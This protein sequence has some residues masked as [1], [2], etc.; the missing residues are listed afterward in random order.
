MQR[1]VVL[2]PDVLVCAFYDPRAREILNQWRDGLILPVV[3]RELLLLYVRTLNQAGL[4]HE[5]I[6]KWSLWLTTPGKSLYL[7]NAAP[8]QKSGLELCDAVAQ[9]HSASVLTLSHRGTAAQI[10]N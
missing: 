1:R 3:T 5:L 6:R 9:Q 7:E 8:M 4:T 2:A 10:P